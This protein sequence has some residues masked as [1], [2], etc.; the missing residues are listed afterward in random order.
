MY[1]P[2]PS[3]NGTNHE[4]LF[5]GTPG[6]VAAYDAAPPRMVTAADGERYGRRA[7]R[8]LTTGP[9]M[10]F[11]LEL[12]EEDT[13]VRQQEQDE[14]DTAMEASI[15]DLTTWCKKHLSQKDIS[16]VINILL[17]DNN[18]AN[19][20]PAPFPG[21]PRTG[22]AADG[23]SPF[24]GSMDTAPRR[25]RAPALSTADRLSL[26]SMCPGLARIKIL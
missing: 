12:E 25:R 19:D 3:P 16:R 24:Y 2:M 13:N 23:S 17:D 1:R 21:R 4:R 14:S 8:P 7:A 6:P 18:G 11:D 20:E 5:I 15:L 10:A 22:A 26:D 9:A